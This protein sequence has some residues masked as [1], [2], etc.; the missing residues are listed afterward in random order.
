ME[1]MHGGELIAEALKAQ[2]AQFLFTLCGG[3]ISPILVACKQRG[4]RVIDVRH[5][6]TAVF[7]ADAVA[8]LTGI[9][10]VAAVTAGPGVTNTMT[11]VKNAQLAQ[12]PVVILGGATAT[13][14]K[15]RG[16]LQDIDQMALFKPHVK[17]AK[18]VRKVRDLA[19]ALEQAF[20]VAKSDVPGP[21]FV[22]C[23]VDLLYN[24]SIVREWY[25]VK[26]QKAI[27]RSARGPTLGE[28]VLKWYLKHHVNQ[29]FAGARAT[30]P[31]PRV[32][33]T[34]P[35]PR[36]IDLLKAA[37]KLQ[38][39]E[40]PLLLV[41]SQAML[42]A[43]EAQKVASAVERLGIPVYLSGM[44][45][46][47]LGRPHPLLMRHKRRDA[48]KEADL[49]ILAG[50][51]CDFRLDYGRH[52]RRSTYLISANRSRIEVKKNRRP[53]L[54]VLGD[55]GLFLRQLTA[56]LPA[57]DGWKTWREQLR[58]R[59]DE[60]EKEIHQQ[61]I[62]STTL[63]NPVHLCLEIEKA[64]PPNGLIVADGGDFVGTASYTVSPPGPLTWLDPGVFGTL[65]V[66]AGFALGAKL[67][68]PEA[69]VWIL[70][71]DGSVGYSL[72]EFDTF[73]RH[74]IPVLAIIGND[75][76]WTQIAREQIEMLKDDVGTVLRHT[77]YHL[78]AEGLG[79]KGFL[80]KEPQRISEVLQGARK[81]VTQGHPVLVNAH[82]GKTAF[83][84]GSISM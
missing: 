44:A 66:G 81:A 5:E 33:I 49:V 4:I 31:S 74:G 18:S 59:D 68:R 79:G 10:G 80:L 20:R 34:P 36:S 7:A 9:P 3:H 61:S 71:G 53:H 46:G 39:A 12:S 41:G 37:E 82:I 64:I 16:A 29:L 75:A 47:L 25:G 69:E 54:A 62:E 6:A 22:E 42:E 57:N 63:L 26:S 83:R 70:F 51:P 40:R 13:A 38:R 30:A 65:G 50:V 73:V 58:Q 48:L 45:R 1:P 72:S 24:E 43:P 15:G 23:P 35:R 32:S 2:G 56:L 21:V 17:S 28:R 14:L 60:R 76:C 8:R 84:K 67:C 19:P 78:V 11:A 55:P 52:L 27:D 77:D